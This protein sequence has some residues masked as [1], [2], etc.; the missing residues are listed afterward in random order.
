[1]ETSGI[2]LVALTR[3]SGRELNRQFREREISKT[4][5]ALVYGI[6]ED[7]NGTITLPLMADTKNRPC[8]IVD[9]ENGKHATTE[10]KVRQRFVSRETLIHQN[11]H[12]IKENMT[13]L[14]LNP[15]T[16]R[17][18]QLRVH[19]H[20]IGHPIVGDTLYNLE[21]TSR[22]MD[23]SKGER[24]MLHA[25][26]IC[27]K[28]PTTKAPMEL[29]VEARF[30]NAEKEPLKEEEDGRNTTASEGNKCAVMGGGAINGNS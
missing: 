1:M 2:L 14:E 26:R 16:G 8:Q 4:Y 29:V 23:E 17:T 21:K 3:E 28:H 19:L 13:L 18:H 24:L 25:E 12:M 20:A 30:F 7:D 6:I 15:I 22:P 5:V 11:K 9:L 27:F 10:W